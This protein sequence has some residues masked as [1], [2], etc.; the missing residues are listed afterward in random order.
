VRSKDEPT[1]SSHA[2]HNHLVPKNQINTR[3]SNNT[4]QVQS[5]H[6]KNN[7]WHETKKKVMI[8]SDIDK[9]VVSVWNG[10]SWISFAFTGK[11][12]Q[13][14]PTLTHRN[15]NIRT[16]LHNRIHRDMNWIKRNHLKLESWKLNIK[17]IGRK[18]RG[19]NNQRSDHHIGLSC[20]CLNLDGNAV[21]QPR[22]WYSP[23]LWS[24]TILSS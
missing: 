16:K 3:V 12:E 13:V 1:P 23:H 19:T 21:L 20:T 17:W 14:G 15:M 7:I 4:Q 5:Q 9:T 2:C 10:Q 8:K 24:E 11:A 22:H 18:I 6:E